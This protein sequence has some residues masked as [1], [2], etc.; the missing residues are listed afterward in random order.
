MQDV[1]T[2]SISR[3][4]LFYTEFGVC[5]TIQLTVIAYFHPKFGLTDT[6]FC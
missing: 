4:E 6:V 3:E 1:D 2:Y 5:M